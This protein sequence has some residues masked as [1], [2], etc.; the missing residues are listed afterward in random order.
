MDL[1]TLA[2]ILAC[3]ACKGDIEYIEK[4]GHS[5][6]LC[7]ACAKIYPIRDNIP[8]M[9]INEAIPMNDWPEREKSQ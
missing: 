5:G 7:P 8:I 1:Q 3:P 2:S 6:Y 9:L 4:D